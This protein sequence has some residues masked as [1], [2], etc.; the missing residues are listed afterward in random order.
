MAK[1]FRYSVE[2]LEQG[3]GILPVV[4]PFTYKFDIVIQPRQTA[5]RGGKFESENFH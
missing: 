2:I 5:A 4:R 1:L 3:S